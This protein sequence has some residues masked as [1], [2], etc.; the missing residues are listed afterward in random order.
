MLIFI[1]HNIKLFSIS[2]IPKLLS[3]IYK[4]LGQPKICL[5]CQI[6]SGITDEIP[7]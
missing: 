6:T 3:R 4:I 1:S 7:Q 2:T 5:N